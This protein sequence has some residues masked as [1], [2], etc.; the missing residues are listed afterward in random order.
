[1]NYSKV[2]VDTSAWLAG[3]L[4]NEKSHE[5][6]KEKFKILRN[7]GVKLYTSNDIVSETVTRLIYDNQLATVKKFISLLDESVE[8]ETLFELW[9]DEQIQQEA[10]N[11]VEKFFEHKLSFT[12]ATTVVLMSRFNIDAVMTLDSDFKKIGL[13]SIP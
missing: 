4:E 2:I 9:T 8:A 3:I 1:M 6:I 5:E 12:D 7:E 13:R 11:V 10:L